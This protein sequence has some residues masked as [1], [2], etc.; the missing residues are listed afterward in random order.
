MTEYEALELVAMH[1]DQVDAAFEFWVTVSFG[2]LVAIHIARSSMARQ[3]KFL[4]CALYI[5]ASLIAIFHT[6]GDLIQALEHMQRIQHS[7]SATVWNGMG[8]VLRMIVYVAGT[9]SI[10]VAIFR[11]DSWIK[12]GST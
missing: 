12:N 3:L 4:R 11:Y 6:V 1:V 8:V 5:F 7:T 10:S 9:V 2:V